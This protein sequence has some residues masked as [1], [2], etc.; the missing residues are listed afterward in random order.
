MKF[1]DEALIRVEAGDGGDGC[2]SFRREKYIPFGGPD[3]GDGGDG[4]SIY[5]VAHAELNT[6]ADFR[7]TQRFQAER[8]Q[9]GMGANRTG[10]SGADLDILTPVGTLV[11]DADTDELIGD[12]VEP[13]QRLLV[14]HG[15]F[16][17]LGNTRYKSS[18]NR[19]PRQFKPGTPG[20][21]R[22]L[23]LELKV[24]ADVGL[25]GLPNAGKSTLIRAVSAAQPKV[26]DYP[27]T[28]LHPHLG[29]VRVGPLQS[30]VMADIPG[31]IEGASEGAGLGMQFLRHLARTRLLLHLVDVSPYSDSGDPVRDVEIILGE[32]G[33]YSAELAE[34]ERWLVLNK[35]DLLPEEER[36]GRMAK[37][38]AALHWMGPAFGVSAVSGEGTDALIQAVM[39]RLEETEG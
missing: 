28:T 18:T 37:I 9:K 24:I 20:E 38:V 10:R 27:F 35:L 22:N 21:A 6:L 12:L 11:W 13:G 25:L 29:V 33:R 19:A 2:V 1:V 34:R 8:G 7:F 14:A 23:R 4:G 3:G 16:H 5:L 39:M 32:L 30:F 31:L 26:A 17:G 15:G 36:E